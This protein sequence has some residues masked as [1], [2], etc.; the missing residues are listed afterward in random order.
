[1]TDPIRFKKNCD[2]DLPVPYR[3]SRGAAGLDLYAL[4]AYTVYPGQ[5]IKINTGWDI[6]IPEDFVGIVKDRGS[7]AFTGLTVRAGV[8]DN[9]FRGHL[10]VVVHNDFDVKIP[11][12]KGQRVAQLVV[13]PCPKFACIEVSEF[14]DVTERGADAFGSTGFGI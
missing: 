11:V 7:M 10:Q 5:T 13:V 1:M 8:I 4:G 9:D 6:A 3:H 12:G 14:L 2:H